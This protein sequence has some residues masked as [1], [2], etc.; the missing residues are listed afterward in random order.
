MERSEVR[1]FCDQLRHAREN[2]LANAE[3][4]DEIIH[5]IERIGSFRYRKI[6]DLGK[7]KE[8]IKTLANQSAFAEEIPMRW[9]SLHV[10]FSVLYDLAKE[11]RNDA[12]HQGAFARHL[13]ANAIELSLMLEDALKRSLE[14]PIAADYMVRNP[15]CAELWQP[16][17]FIRQQLL[18]HSFTYLP[19]KDRQG[20]WRL[21]SDL[22][23]ARY[24]GT[25]PGRKGR[26]AQPLKEAVEIQLLP[27]NICFEDTPLEVALTRVD[28]TPLLICGQDANEQVLLGILTA[29]DLL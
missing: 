29:F 12:S 10:P 2:A 27:A 25:N 26:L 19:V 14:S 20:I 6:G 16:V 22:A 24:L 4:F 7:Y 13:T 15:I 8:Q 18:A 11:G 23:I 9:G 17:S 3:A 28:S 5:V 21:V 1:T